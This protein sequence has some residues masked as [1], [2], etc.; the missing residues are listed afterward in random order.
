MPRYIAVHSIPMG[1]AELM[2]M[3]KEIAPKIPP[4]FSWKET[5]S[6]FSDGKH[7]C[8]W[9]AP[10]QEALAEAFKANN[11]PYDAIYPVRRFDPVSMQFEP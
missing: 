3:L 7:F 10:S 8:N 5:F 11:M 1:E 2:G 6:D 9:E 4:G